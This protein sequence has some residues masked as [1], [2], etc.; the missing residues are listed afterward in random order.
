MVDVNDEKDITKANWK[1][2]CKNNKQKL[3][4]YP[5]EQ[6]EIDMRKEKGKYPKTFNARY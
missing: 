5:Y 6:Y 1:I 3:K 4:D 2:F